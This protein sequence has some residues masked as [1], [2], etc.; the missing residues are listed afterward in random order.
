MHRD[1]PW[2][3]GAYRR[4]RSFDSGSRFA[5]ELR[6][7]GGR[8]ACVAVGAAVGVLVSGVA[9]PVGVRV[10]GNDGLF[11]GAGN[12]GLF[13]GAEVVG[14]S[15]GGPV[16]TGV[17]PSVGVAVGTSDGRTVSVA[18]GVC[19]QGHV[20]HSLAQRHFSM[21]IRLYTRCTTLPAALC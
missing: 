8:T 13:V 16:G 5:P 18:V 1:I 7:S 21:L 2:R 15:V 20:L 19:K 4:S 9:M 17:G 12:D 10:A 3:L 11:V 14:G 6:G